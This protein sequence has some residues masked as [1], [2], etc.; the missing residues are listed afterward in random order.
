MSCT[1]LCCTGT[2]LHILKASF[3]PISA[4]RSSSGVDCGTKHSTSWVAGF[5]RGIHSLAWDSSNCPLMKFDTF[6]VLLLLD[7]WR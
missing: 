2:S 1:C 4:L 7:E 3:A 6:L 5:K